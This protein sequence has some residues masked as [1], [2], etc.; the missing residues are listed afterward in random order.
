MEFERP[1]RRHYDVNLV[2]LINVIFL[3]LI[4]FMVAGRV[5][6]LDM[7]EI[8][9]PVAVSGFSESRKPPVIYFGVDGRIAVNDDLVA[10][11]DF[12]TIVS[13]LLLENPKQEMVIKADGKVAAEKLIW[14]MNIVEQ[15]GGTLVSLITQAA[16]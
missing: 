9:V 15:A 16:K 13:T 2:P 10:E 11:K 6:K 12:E 7:F 4:F 5:D 3:L 8:D 1:K 14:A